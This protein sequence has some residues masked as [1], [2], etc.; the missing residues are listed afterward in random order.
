MPKFIERSRR[1]GDKILSIHISSGLSGTLN[2]AKVVAEMV[3]EADITF[4]DSKTLSAALGWQVQAAALAAVKNWPI[5]KILE[6][7]EKIRDQVNG[8]FTLKE[9]RYLIHGGR[10]SH[11]KGLM[12]QVLNIKPIIEVEHERGTYNNAGQAVTFKRAINQLAELNLNQYGSNG[13]TAGSD[14]SWVMS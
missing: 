5:N 14:R 8:M 6:R 11:I 9:M 4:W 3:P 12:A 1:F 7:L 10:V 2:S 13:K